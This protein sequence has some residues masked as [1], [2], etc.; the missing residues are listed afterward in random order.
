MCEGDS[1]SISLDMSTVLGSKQG[2]Y[3]YTTRLKKTFNTHKV[4]NIEFDAEWQDCQDVW[5]APLWITP[6]LWVAPQGKSGEIDLIES[7]RNH[8]GNALTTSI[9][10]SQHPNPLCFEPQWGNAASSGGPLHFIATIDDTGTFSMTKYAHP[11]KNGS[12]GELVSRYP[13][14]LE[15]NLGSV[16]NQ[17]FH[18]V[19][20][21][22][23]GGSGNGGWGA[24][25]TM[26]WH[27]QCKYTIANIKITDK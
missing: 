12:R 22:W 14:Y 19:S 24:C 6:F 17:Q 11:Y 18:F 9:I 13:L 15:T 26:N 7:C 27:T 4:K 5:F 21:L 2:C 23:N 16:T 3:A 8:R 10:C 20:D 25:G 1:T